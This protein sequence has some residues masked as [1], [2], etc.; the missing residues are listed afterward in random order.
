[1]KYKTLLTIV[2][3]R[4]KLTTKAPI[5]RCIR[6]MF[7]AEMWENVSGSTKSEGGRLHI[8]LTMHF[9]IMRIF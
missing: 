4:I 8:Y 2:D 6:G 1:M 9:T 7:V 5:Q 3:M